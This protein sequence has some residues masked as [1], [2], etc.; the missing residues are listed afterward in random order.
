MVA[1]ILAIS[2]MMAFLNV[3]T[4]DISDDID[5]IDVTGDGDS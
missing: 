5:S 1:V 2:A 3:V 4:V